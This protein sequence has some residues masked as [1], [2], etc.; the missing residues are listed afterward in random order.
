MPSELI[1]PVVGAK[2]DQLLEFAV[3][4]E[5]HLG[6]IFL[7]L[8]I[9]KHTCG[10]LVVYNAWRKCW[11]LPGGLVEPDE[12]PRAAAIR[13]FA[14]ESGQTP[15]NVRLIGRI[16][17]NEPAK[18]R[19]IVGAVFACDLPELTPF[20]PSEEIDAVAL[21]PSEGLELD[22]IDRALLSFCR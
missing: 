4:E 11:E 20:T 2:G 22:A 17:I 13:E 7:S 1:F 14:E 19:V 9:A 16:Q 3:T 18:E 12:T 10:F 6:P 8:M 5:A 21:W 15:E